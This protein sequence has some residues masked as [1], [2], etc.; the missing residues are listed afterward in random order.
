MRIKPEATIA[1]LRVKEE[2]PMSSVPV[3]KKLLLAG[4]AML[5]LTFTLGSVALVCITEIG[6]HL[7]EI[8]RNTVRQQ[9]LVHEM[10][11][12][13]SFMTGGTKGILLRGLQHNAIGI[14]WN[15]DDFRV[16]SGSLQGDIDTLEKMRL[17]PETTKGL[18][19]LIDVLAAT[20]RAN[21]KILAAARAGDM[22]QAFAAYNGTM[23]QLELEQKAAIITM[24]AVQDKALVSQSDAAEA[25]VVDSRRITGVLLALALVLGAVFVWVVRQVVR[26]VRGSVSELGDMVEQIAAAANQFSSASRTLAEG[27]SEQAASIGETSHSVSEITILVQRTR[28]NS[29][30][31]ANMMA[32]SSY[33]FE[34]TN[35]LL[36]EMVES[37]EGINASSNAI[38][39]IIRIIDEIAFQTNILSLNAAVEAARAGAAG[40][41]FAVVA[42]EVRSLAQRCAQ[43]AKDTTDL[44]D[45]SVKRS[46]TG[47]LKVNQVANAI[48]SI[49]DQSGKI[50][51]LVD[52]ITSHSAEEGDRIK[53]IGTAIFEIEKVTRSSAAGAKQGASAAEQLHAQSASLTE[54]VNRM[55]VMVD[56]RSSTATSP[57]QRPSSSLVATAKLELPKWS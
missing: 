1:S 46:T 54:V 31:T 41:G 17:A 18:N 26:L 39:K 44:I 22:E 27:A 45:D 48:R 10:E 24:L 5:L 13:I 3:G 37:M 50:A 2:G 8:V 12:N 43:A 49:T 9:T 11:R 15:A 7:H 19:H 34:R 23:K 33:E 57:R 28:Q 16:Y 14:G 32:G 30:A 35:H 40:L 47:K 20:R 55:R 36:E 42:E 29:Q 51:I 4:G 53:R 25:S 56:G 6:E 52:Q 38:S 21:D